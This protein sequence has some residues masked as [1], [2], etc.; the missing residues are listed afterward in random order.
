MV[1]IGVFNQLGYPF[2]D[3]TSE[4]QTVEYTFVQ[5]HDFL[6]V[7]SSSSVLNLI[8]LT[9]YILKRKKGKIYTD[10]CIF[11]TATNNHLFLIF[12][13]IASIN[14]KYQSTT[15]TH[16]QMLA[17]FCMANSSIT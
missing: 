1:R 6:F 8:R 9:I 17:S 16:I 11:L 5:F 2:W 15:I 14:V 13:V 3:D 10:H 4:I 7:L 12:K